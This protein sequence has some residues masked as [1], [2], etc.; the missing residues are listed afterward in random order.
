MLLA[1]LDLAVTPCVPAAIE[2]TTALAGLAQEVL[3]PGTEEAEPLA[4]EVAVAGVE[5]EYT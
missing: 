4:V 5:D 3:V 1:A 2:E